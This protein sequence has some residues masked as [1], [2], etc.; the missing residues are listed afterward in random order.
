MRHIF[1]YLLR[2]FHG[3]F[4]LIIIFANSANAKSSPFYNHFSDS[5]LRID[6][7]FGGGPEGPRIFIDSQSKIPGWAGRKSNLKKN[8]LN[9]NG[10]I[11]V[12]DPVTGDT[13]YIN[14]FSTLFQ[15]WL[16]TPEAASQSMSFENSFLV[17]LPLKDADIF[18]D[19]K[20]NRHESI[21]MLQHKY[22]KDDELIANKNH[23][24][25]PYEII[26]EGN[27][28]N[29]VIDVAI[30]AEGYTDSEMEL[31]LSKAGEITEEILSYEPF[32]SNKDKFRFLAVKTS[33]AENGV[34]IPLKNIWKNT[35]FG[36]HFSTFYSARYLTV[37][38][39]WKMHQ[40]LEGIPYEH[41][42]VI[43]NTDNYGGGGIFNN[44]Q[45]TAADNEFTLPVTVHEFGHS[46][47][48]LADEYF[49]EGEYDDTYPIDIEPWEKNITTL[50][51]FESKW[52]DK[53]N[54]DTPVPTPWEKKEDTRQNLIKPRTEN[55]ESKNEIGVYEGGGY[56]P[57]NIYRPF[58]TC[59]MKDN[60]HPSFCKVCED[61]IQEVILF[62][63]EE[64]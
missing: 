14:S 24:P 44:Y 22:R 25:L 12:A 33:S 7:I 60:F 34:S 55:F 27:N 23:T 9:G 16:N 42:I 56:K 46:F 21:A 32:L 45:V 50:V 41:I 30:I 31:F 2:S 17:P 18:I 38:R 47:S 15:E 29:N 51:N 4:L 28:G 52:K 8:V 1:F 57:E 36:A 6:Y 58:I 43:V 39:V 5:T 40:A 3:L 53:L 10:T 59:R 20:N 11:V 13:L 48:G 35:A 54:S 26:H 64:N 63:T 19:L 49:Y 62:Y 61:I 37:P